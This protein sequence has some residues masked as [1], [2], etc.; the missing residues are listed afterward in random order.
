MS[1]SSPE[2]RQR[3]RIRRKKNIKVDQD[4]GAASIAALKKQ[5]EE[6]NA[7]AKAEKDRRK[8][9]KRQLQEANAKAEEANA[10]AE[11]EKKQRREANAKAEEANARAEE[12]KKQRRE[13][14][15]KAEE[16][17]A[18]AEEEKKLRR[19][20]NARAEE[21]EAQLRAQD[22]LVQQQEQLAELL[23]VQ[24]AATAKSKSNPPAVKF[25]GALQ[26]HF[27]PAG[28]HL[29]HCLHCCTEINQSEPESFVPSLISLSLFVGH[30]S[31]LLLIQIP[32]LL[33]LPYRRQTKHLVQQQQQHHRQ[34]LGENHGHLSSRPK[35]SE[36]CCALAH[37]R[38]PC[39]T[40]HTAV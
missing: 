26:P 40:L 8:Q 9:V 39:A 6:A 25:Y 7:K 13:A 27:N 4:D 30:P 28:W 32:T 14:N 3:K 37:S 2:G 1:S 18:R 21:A 29:L 12:E 5:L 23:R 10:R 11:E 15:A 24:C 38:A 20:A 34:L 17:N 31:L 19:E 35:M 22:E 33:L 36:S 16:A